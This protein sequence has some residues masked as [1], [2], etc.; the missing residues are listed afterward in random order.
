MTDWNAKYRTHFRNMILF[1]VTY[2]GLTVAADHFQI[3]YWPAR[4]LQVFTLFGALLSAAVAGHAA[5]V[6]RTRGC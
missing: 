6:S 5:A 4:V 1:T 3:A 2:V